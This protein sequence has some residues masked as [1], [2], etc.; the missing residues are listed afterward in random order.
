MITRKFESKEM[1]VFERL[2]E[3]YGLIVQNITQE[4]QTGDVVYKVSEP[5]H[6]VTTFEAQPGIPVTLTR[7]ISYDLAEEILS[8]VNT[9][10]IGS[11]LRKYLISDFAQWAQDQGVDVKGEIEDLLITLNPAALESA[12]HAAKDYIFTEVEEMR[13]MYRINS[14][15][16]STDDG[17]ARI[18]YA[19]LEQDDERLKV[20]LH[21]YVN[22]DN[23]SAVDE[24]AE[25]FSEDDLKIARE[26]TKVGFWPSQTELTK[27]KLQETKDEREHLRRQIL[28][29]IREGKITVDEDA[30]RKMLEQ[31]YIPEELQMLYSGFETDG[32]NKL[33]A[34]FIDGALTIRKV[35]S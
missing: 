16:T 28:D 34:D 13:R 21:P 11:A 12:L 14:I 9:K 20:E 24:L 8:S 23:Y 22:V 4:Q 2:A 7:R 15:P 27:I 10:N 29:Q 35:K 26:L 33:K 1:K 18:A 19:V 32:Q 25:H 31:H 6:Q 30:V 5:S 17:Y 3:K